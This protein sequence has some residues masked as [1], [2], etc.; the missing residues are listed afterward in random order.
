MCARSTS[1]RNT[2]AAWP[3]VNGGSSGHG[4]V[5]LAGN[6]GRAAGCVDE[7]HAVRVK[8]LTIKVHRTIHDTFDFLS[9]DDAL[10]LL[11]GPLALVLRRLRSRALLV[12]APGLGFSFDALFLGCAVAPGLNLPAGAQAHSTGH[13]CGDDPQGGNH[14]PATTARASRW[15][16]A[17]VCTCGLPG[18]QVRK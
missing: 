17:Q 2:V 8:A 1:A 18:R 3:S 14:F 7:A 16:S 12:I 4:C 10:H 11:L 6:G 9:D 13:G 15:N 5:R